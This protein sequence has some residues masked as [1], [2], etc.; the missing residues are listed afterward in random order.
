MILLVMM[1]F[2]IS[3]FAQSDSIKFH[4]VKSMKLDQKSNIELA[5][6]IIDKDSTLKAEK[7]SNAKLQDRLTIA[8]A[9]KDLWGGVPPIDYLIGMFFALLGIFIHTAIFTTKSVKANNGTPNKFS[10]T[11]W[12]NNNST[13]I[14]HWLGIIAIIEIGMRFCNE[15]FNV[16][17]TMFIAF[18]L[19]FLLD[20]FISFLRGLK[21]K[22]NLT[23][24]PTIQN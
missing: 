14:M 15:F 3:L 5:M 9:K 7:D 24:T 12:W 4:K 6:Q 8:E 13:K 23:N 22:T 18:L 10:W 19:G 21:L 2:S 20:Q 16:K 11:Y 1:I 17:L